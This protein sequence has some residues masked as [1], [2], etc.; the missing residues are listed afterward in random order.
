MLPEPHGMG[1][2]V[3]IR[4]HVRLHIVTEGDHNAAPIVFLHGFPEFWWAWRHQLKFFGEQGWRTIAPDL[5]G[6]NHSSKPK[7]GYDPR[8]QAEDIALLLEEMGY[9]RAIIVGNDYGG[10]IAYAISLYFPER[11]KALVILNSLHPGAWPN[12]RRLGKVGLRVF[13]RLA[14]LGYHVADPLISATNQAFGI[15]VIFKLLAHQKK[16]MPQPVRKAFSKAYQRSGGSAIAY[17]PAFAEWLATQFPKAPIVPHP[18]LV[19]WPGADFTAP[20]WVTRSLPKTVPHSQL[21]KVEGAGH[22]LQQEQPDLVNQAILQFL[23]NL[24]HINLS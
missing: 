22:W 23:H 21:V 6:V 19:L 13:I 18:T 1:H 10:I 9:Q 7:E 5:R 20:F 17:A 8:T 12:P 15:G 3:T 4:P 2:Y 11:V 24:P 14:Y 16:T